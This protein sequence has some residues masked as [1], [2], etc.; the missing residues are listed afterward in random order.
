MRRRSRPR[1]PGAVST[2][3]NP[4]MWPGRGA[5]SAGTSPRPARRALAARLEDLDRDPVARRR[6][7]TAR[8]RA[9]RA[10]RSTPTTSWPGT[11]ANGDRQVR[12]CTARGRCRRGRTPRPAAGRR[13]RRSVR[14]RRRAPRAGGVTSARGLGLARHRP[15]HTGSRFSTKARGPSRGVIGG[16]HLSGAS[17]FSIL[18]AAA[19]GT[20]D[21]V[22]T[23]SLALRRANG[24]PSTMRRARSI[25]VGRTSSGGRARLTNPM[26]GRGRPR[27]ARRRG[28]SPSPPS[29]GS[30]GPAGPGN[31]RR[32]RCPA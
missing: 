12:R 31:H 14:S 24:A 6:P 9:A 2:S 28:G 17:A 29:T 11:N 8:P 21:V 7:P 15:A 1:G 23:A 32:P 27:S 3:T 10:A 4:Y 25:A 18:Y 30:G 20:P 22:T 19:S 13:R 26:R 16:H 5:R